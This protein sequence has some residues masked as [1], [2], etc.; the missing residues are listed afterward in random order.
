MERDLRDAVL[1]A[2]MN[3]D[4]MCVDGKFTYLR[5]NSV[6]TKKQTKQYSNPFECLKEGEK[7]V[8]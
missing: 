2:L 5:G 4:M 7:N 8:K 1:A 3:G 6:V